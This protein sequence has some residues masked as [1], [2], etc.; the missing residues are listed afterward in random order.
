MLT[1]RLIIL[2]RY[3]DEFDRYLH[4]FDNSFYAEISVENCSSVDNDGLMWN[5]LN[6]IYRLQIVRLI[7]CV[8]KSKNIKAVH[9]I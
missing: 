2:L 3:A 8:N 5:S 7:L 6:Q 4:S 9:P 1:I